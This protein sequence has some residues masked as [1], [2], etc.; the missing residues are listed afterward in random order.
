MLG[1]TPVVRGSESVSPA[2]ILKGHVLLGSRYCNVV[3]DTQQVHSW[4]LRSVYM[5]F[6]ATEILKR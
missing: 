6:T 4:P 1:P 5:C 3:S 2:P